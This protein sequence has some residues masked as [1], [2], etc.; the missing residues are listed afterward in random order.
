MINLKEAKNFGSFFLIIMSIL[1]IVVSG[2]A[3]GIVYFTMDSIQTAFEA[4]DCVITDN[5]LVGSCQELF[6]LSIYPILELKDILVWAHTFLIFGMVLGMLFLGY[7]SGRSS[8]LMGI[9]ILFVIIL[10]YI[11]TEVSNIYRTFLENPLFRNIM[12]EFVFYNR[13]MMNLPA[14]VFIVSL[15]AAML[16]VVNYQRTRINQDTEELDY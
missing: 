1:I 11:G 9:M 16:G 12:I 7:K 5:T 15:F 10:T 3:F 14:F 2:I 13:V 6:A 8:F 4:Q